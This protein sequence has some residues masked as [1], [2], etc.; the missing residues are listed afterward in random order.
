MMIAH[1]VFLLGLILSDGTFISRLSLINVLT[2][3]TRFAIS[4]PLKDFASGF[5]LVPLP[6]DVR[7][8][9]EQSSRVYKPAFRYLRATDRAVR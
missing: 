8:S 5:V 7:S 4:F 6:S 2:I 1:L 3:V 9:D